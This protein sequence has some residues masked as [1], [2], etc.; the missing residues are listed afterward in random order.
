MSR[1]TPVKKADSLT[2]EVIQGKTDYVAFSP[3]S[4]AAFKAANELLNRGMAIDPVKST[5]AFILPASSSLANELANSWAL[6]VLPVD[7]FPDDAVLM[8]KMRIAVYGDEGVAIA[9]DE[10]GFEYDEV[11]ISELN[12]GTISSYDVFLNRSLSGL[13]STVTVRRRL[14]HGSLQAAT[15]LVC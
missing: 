7:E 6:D 1:Q 12:A 13:R 3:T 11:S 8:K 15:M 14:E 2:G 4:L 10:L 5:G 9:L